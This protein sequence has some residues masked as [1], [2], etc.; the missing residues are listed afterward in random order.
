[1]ITCRAQPQY[2]DETGYF[3]KKEFHQINVLIN[4]NLIDNVRGEA[5][6]K[7]NYF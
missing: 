4:T 7:M 5:D 6:F 3:F 2:P 1:M